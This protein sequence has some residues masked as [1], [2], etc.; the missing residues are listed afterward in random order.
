M[1]TPVE[2]E[3]KVFKS[4]FGYDK[5]EVDNFL[6]EIL[7][8]YE[9]LY[10]NCGD[11]TEKIASLEEKI[12][13]YNS[14]EKT[15]QKALILAEKTAEDT[16]QAAKKEAEI[17]V[18]E[19][20]LKANYIVKDAKEELS[21]IRKQSIDLIQQYELY[22]AQ[23]KQLT[24]VQLDL[25]ESEAFQLKVANLTGNVYEEKAENEDSIEAVDEAKS[26]TLPSLDDEAKTATL[27]SLDDEAKAATLPNLDDED[28]Q[29]NTAIDKN[30]ESEND[31]LESE[32][33]DNYKI[34]F[35]DLS[36]YE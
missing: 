8:G 34:D 29:T 18:D 3:G 13:Y 33:D 14:I 24:K 12:E 11:Y 20:N 30:T 36:D 7:V 17:I 25:I 4:G 10:T 35:F 21:N 19:A 6:Q 26:T 22:K 16:K 23:F 28:T 2:I 15:L 31:T 5:K 1:I 9:S 32:S 27:P